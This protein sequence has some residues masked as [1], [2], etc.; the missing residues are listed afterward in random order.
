MFYFKSSTININM[1]INN[2]NTL[3]YSKLNYCKVLHLSIPNMRLTSTST[4]IDT[5]CSKEQPEEKVKENVLKPSVGET[6]ADLAE[7]NI[8]VHVY[9]MCKTH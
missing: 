1:I 8:E 9:N 7:N 3:W 2:C 4:K 6:S 5:N